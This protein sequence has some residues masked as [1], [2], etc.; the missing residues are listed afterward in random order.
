MQLYANFDFL[1]PTRYT[2]KA[3]NTWTKDKQDKMNDAVRRAVMCWE[4]IDTEAGHYAEPD[5]ERPEL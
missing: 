5:E 4:I 1:C 3:W 2:R